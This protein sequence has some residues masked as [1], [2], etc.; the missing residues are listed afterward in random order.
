M[1]HMT[2]HHIVP[3]LYYSLFGI[4]FMICHGSVL[5]LVPCP[6]PCPLLSLVL[7]CP[8]SCPFM[9]LLLFLSCPV[10]SCPP[11]LSSVLSAVL[12]CPVLCPVL[13][14]PALSCP[15]LSCPLFCHVPSADICSVPFCPALSCPVC[16]VS[17][18]FPSLGLRHVLSCPKGSPL[19]EVN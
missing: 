5:S 10:L 7:F 12:S 4:S 8:L 16:P 11:F 15:V 13:S 2:F 18:A 9:S 1:Q 6:V 14:C 19:Y 17:Y 3:M